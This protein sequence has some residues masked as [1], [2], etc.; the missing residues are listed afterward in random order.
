MYYIH[1]A[2]GYNNRLD[3]FSGYKSKNLKKAIKL[4]DSLKPSKAGVS[5][6]VGTTFQKPVYKNF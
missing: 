5:L 3:M 4:C 6:L 2:N 1:Y